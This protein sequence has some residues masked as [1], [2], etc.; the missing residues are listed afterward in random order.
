M[1]NFCYFLHYY[2]QNAVSLLSTVTKI[3][4]VGH[5]S[6]V[7]KEFQNLEKGSYILC[8]KTLYIKSGIVLYA[9][10]YSRKALTIYMSTHT[11]DTPDSIV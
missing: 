2:T 9:A 11:I 5:K 8:F 1:E 6:V 4:L 10:V 7:Q 3:F